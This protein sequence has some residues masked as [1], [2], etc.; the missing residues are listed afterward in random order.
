MNCYG[1][2][3]GLSFDP[4]PADNNLALI[5]PWLNVGRLLRIKTNID[6]YV[7]VVWIDGGTRVN[8]GRRKAGSLSDLR[9]LDSTTARNG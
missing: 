2:G 7:S 1:N 8:L 9:R 3:Y 6:L 5:A 4:F